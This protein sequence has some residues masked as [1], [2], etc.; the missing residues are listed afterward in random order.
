MAKE[1]NNMAS[2]RHLKGVSMAV[3]NGVIIGWR[4]NQ[5]NGESQ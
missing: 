3:R 5:R 1:N 4:R 2:A